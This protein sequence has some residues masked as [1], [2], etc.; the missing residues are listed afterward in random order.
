MTRS[1]A[2]GVSYDYFI[3]FVTATI[4]TA[5]DVPFSPSLGASPQELADARRDAFAAAIL[6]IRRISPRH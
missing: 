6:A 3:D 1:R 2:R 5:D 4:I